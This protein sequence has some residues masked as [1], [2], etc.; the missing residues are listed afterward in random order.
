MSEHPSVTL[1]ADL[2][3]FANLVGVA[4]IFVVAKADAP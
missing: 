4:E 2:Q 1:R 3:R